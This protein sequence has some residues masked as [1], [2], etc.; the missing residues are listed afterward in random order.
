MSMKGLVIICDRNKSQEMKNLLYKMIN[1]TQK[2]KKCWT[3]TG[4]W[5]FAPF[6]A[7]GNVTNKHTSHIIREQNRYLKT[8]MNITVTGLQNIGWIVKNS[9]SF[10][11]TL[12][13]L[14]IL[15]VKTKNRN[16]QFNSIKHDHQSYHYFCTV[17]ENYDEAAKWI[18][19]LA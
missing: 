10:A 18:D 4:K 13:K 9:V 14:W 17:K 6:S 15:S 2:E 7:D 12:F 11:A 16:Y 1:K 8:A 19:T 5:L 3:Q